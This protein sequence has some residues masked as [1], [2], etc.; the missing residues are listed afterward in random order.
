M[1]DGGAMLIA[2]YGAL[3]GVRHTL[4]PDHLAAVSTMAAHG[5]SRA[6]VLRISAAWGAGHAALIA[7][8]GIFLA[9]FGWTPPPALARDGEALAGAVLIAIGAWSLWGLRRDHLHAHTHAHDGQPAHTHFHSHRHGPKHDTHPG[10]PAW[11]RRPSTAFF[12]GTVHGLAGN[13]AIAALAV[14][15]TPTRDAA[16][17]FVI[18]FALGSVAG[19][20][21][22]GVFAVWPIIRLSRGAPRARRLVQGAAGIASVA[23]GAFLINGS[24]L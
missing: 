11:I 2:L 4:E 1:A 6:D 3:L 17:L 12:V 15:L 22:A 21:V 16:A 10:P 23:A 5:S 7:L 8:A 24:L 20:S 19:M 18:A 14:L 13:G 9:T